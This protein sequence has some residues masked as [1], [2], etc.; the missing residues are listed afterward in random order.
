MKSKQNKEISWLY[1]SRIL[2]ALLIGIVIGLIGSYNFL[3]GMLGTDHLDGYTTL[4][5]NY[6]TC[7]KEN[8]IIAKSVSSCFEEKNVLVRNFR[9]YGN[10]TENAY[11]SP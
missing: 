7:E 9:L 4:Y 8:S 3:A 10:I 5:H 1:I 2:I 11:K 6:K